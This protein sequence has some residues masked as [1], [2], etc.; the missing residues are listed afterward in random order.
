MK[1]SNKNEVYVLFSQLLQQP[2]G[3]LSLNRELHLV[4]FPKT[5]K[6]PSSPPGPNSGAATPHRNFTH[7][8]LQ[9]IKQLILVL[10][11]KPGVTN[12]SNE[13]WQDRLCQRE[14]LTFYALNI[15]YG[16]V[17]NAFSHAK[18]YNIPAQP[19]SWSLLMEKTRDTGRLKATLVS[20]RE[21]P[22]TSEMSP[23]VLF[24]HSCPYWGALASH[25][26]VLHLQMFWI[27]S[28]I[29]DGTRWLSLG[30]KLSQVWLPSDH[31]TNQWQEP[32]SLSTFSSYCTQLH[33]WETA[34][35]RNDKVPK[36]AL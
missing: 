7:N 4:G 22:N 23:G 9:R 35:L 20:W 6:H 1:Q 25:C 18:P 29:S 5:P 36:F 12:P 2:A 14:T 13:N 16:I 15:I 28:G 21:E 3:A 17:L 24:G 19:V 31:R 33:Q 30:N 34:Q 8:L 27:A 32:W 26:P 10:R 11:I